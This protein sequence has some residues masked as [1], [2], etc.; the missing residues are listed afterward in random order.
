MTTATPRSLTGQ[1][2]EDLNWLEDHARRQAR[3]PERA[4]RLHLAA[5]LVRNC[6]GPYLDNQP[7]VPLHVAVVGGAGVGKSTVANFLSGAAAAESNPQAGFTR[8][9]VAYTQANGPLTWPNHLGFLGPLQRLP[10]PG[11]SNLDEDVYQLRRI[12]PTPETG[13]LK[14]FVIW[15]CPD[16][17][18]WAASG[19]LTRLLEVAGLAD[20]IVYVASDERY[21]DE[22]PTQFLRLLLET[23]KPVV[24]CLMKMNEADAPALVSHFQQEVLHRMPT[25]AL[26]CLAVP[27]LTPEQVADPVRLAAQYRLPLLHQVTVLATPPAGARR[28][29]VV[30]GVEFLHRNQ[31]DLLSAARQDVMALEGWRQLVQQGQQQ[32]D[33]RYQREYLSGERF[34][35]FDAAL[36]RLLE[37]LELPGVGQVISKTL[38]AL[39]TP[40]RLLKGVWDRALTRPQAAGLAEMPVLETALSAWLDLLRREATRRASEHPLWEHVA[41]AFAADLSDRA[42]ERFRQGYREFQIGQTDEVERTARAIY[43]ELEKNPVKL[44]VLRG[45]KL[46]LDVGAIGVTLAAGGVNPHD[47]VLIPL[48]AWISNHIVEMLGR[49][50]V[51]NQRE[52][53]RQRQRQLVTQ[54]LSGPLAEWLAQWPATGGTPFERLQLALQRVPVAV[55]QLM[56]AVQQMAG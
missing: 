52:L 14:D 42:R 20:I 4:S 18:T 34:H 43:E 50:Y 26:S 3:Q 37:L 8:H 32:F 1:L 17:T 49:Q 29:A 40:F 41:H 13:L 30:G 53:A 24:V 47:V 45:M 11:P 7:P 12:P 9:P 21:N 44:N 39:R 22:V 36:V 25:P 55:Q 16:M 23:G 35:S 51:D 10:Q 54:H 19:Y 56:A 38:W 6:I 15:D 33:E 27:F 48:A 28:R 2:A 46:S 5:A 31:D